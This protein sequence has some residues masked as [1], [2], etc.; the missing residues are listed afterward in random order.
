[1]G[2]RKS[3]RE[4]NQQLFRTGNERLT[5][6]LGDELPSSARVPFLCEC[7]DE[8]CDG[9]VEVA[10]TEW[11]AVASKPN[12]FIMVSGHLRS[13]GE[14]VVGALEGYDVVQKPD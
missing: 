12:H 6:T 3:R 10:L 14:M 13:E 8:F 1:M 4:Q 2:S 7:A 9:R 5:T 11:E